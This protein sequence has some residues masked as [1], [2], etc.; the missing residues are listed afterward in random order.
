MRK[1]RGR[2]EVWGRAMCKESDNVLQACNR[3]W[4]KPA[5]LLSRRRVS[6]QHLRNRELYVEEVEVGAQK[7]KESLDVSTLMVC[8]FVW[9]TNVLARRLYQATVY[10][11]CGSYC[12]V[13]F[14]LFLIS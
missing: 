5:T 4:R 7:R 2:M 1:M 3:N 10:Q 14:T 8:S 9:S 11:A 6:N 12:Q 13:G